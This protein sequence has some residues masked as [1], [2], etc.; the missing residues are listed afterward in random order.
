M[1]A[2]SQNILPAHLASSVNLIHTDRARFG[3]DLRALYNYK[4]K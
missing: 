4:Q 1:Q 3:W 2:T